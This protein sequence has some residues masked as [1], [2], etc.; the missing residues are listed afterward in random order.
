MEHVSSRIRFPAPYSSNNDYANLT[1]GEYA[2]A[3]SY[4]WFKYD[5]TALV[6]CLDS[7]NKMLDIQGALGDQLFYHRKNKVIPTYLYNSLTDLLQNNELPNQPIEKTIYDIALQDY[8]YALSEW[9]PRLS[10]KAVCHCKYL[11]YV[12]PEY[13]KA[14]LKTFN[15]GRV[16]IDKQHVFIRQQLRDIENL[17][18]SHEV[19]GGKQDSAYTI[20]SSYCV[21]P[22]TTTNDTSHRSGNA[23]FSGSVAV[24][25]PSIEEVKK[26]TFTDEQYKC[27]ITKTFQESGKDKIV[28]LIDLSQNLHT[29]FGIRD[30]FFPIRDFGYFEKFYQLESWIG[31]IKNSS[32][33]KLYIILSK[34]PN[35]QQQI[36]SID[37]NLACS[38]PS[39]AEGQPPQV[40]PIDLVTF[41]L[42]YQYPKTTPVNKLT[43]FHGTPV[44]YSGQVYKFGTSMV[45]DANRLKERLAILNDQS[46]LPNNQRSNNIC[47]AYE[48][49]LFP[50]ELNKAT[51]YHVGLLPLEV[52]VV[53]FVAAFS[54][55][56][57]AQRQIKTP[58]NGCLIWLA[59]VFPEGF[60]R[61]LPKIWCDAVMQQRLKQIPFKQIPLKQIGV[62]KTSA[63]LAVEKTLD[64]APSRSSSPSPIKN[65]VS[66]TSQHNEASNELSEKRYTE[67]EYESAV[68][69][70]FGRV[71]VE[72]NLDD[73]FSPEYQFS[74]N[75]IAA[76]SWEEQIRL[77]AQW[78]N[79][80]KAVTN[81]WQHISDILHKKT[82]FTVK[83]NLRP[84]PK[85]RKKV[86][87]VP[88]TPTAP[89]TQSATPSATTPATTSA[90][91]SVTASVASVTASVTAPATIEYTAK[92]Y[93]KAVI[94]CWRSIS[95][96]I[97][98][99]QLHP[100]LL[101]ENFYQNDEETVQ[102][103]QDPFLSIVGKR[104][105][106]FNFMKS[107]PESCQLFFEA[108]KAET[109]HVGH[110]G[111]FKQLNEKLQQIVR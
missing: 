38:K 81:C 110:K 9:P 37:A 59:Y 11:A 71:P 106:L 19:S 31:S 42:F 2:K 58:L 103:M 20:A 91:A 41:N 93:K 48:E 107:H 61:L 89:V 17:L 43:A 32:W 56:S 45:R 21:K 90:T 3:V 80:E 79:R 33:K 1:K 108:L 8:E 62:E 54:D 46:K 18:S 15:S 72:I 74:F 73:T 40:N 47:G 64:V 63:E 66:K 67:S 97:N 14:L 69:Y 12:A 98:P 7:M 75:K 88:V 6:M 95:E 92:Q 10:N 76:Q 50:L 39:S 85:Q 84:I 36:Q 49:N 34:Q 77:F 16:K 27:A 4:P 101:R 94:S 13:S 25:K 87:A 105:T 52:V 102:K 109:E 60:E 57:F 78:L 44:S 26:L 70:F 99:D 35:F 111:V 68:L 86:P 5:K 24:D 82:D 22:A 29:A 65:T 28:A 23:F 96:L 83:K 55:W 104:N 30:A 51:L 53:E 100:H